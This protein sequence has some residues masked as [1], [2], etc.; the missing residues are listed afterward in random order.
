MDANRW[1]KIKEVYDRALDLRDEERAG[2]LAEACGDDDD[3]RRE[4]QSLLAAHADAGT[5]LESPAVEAAAREIVADEL[6]SPAPQLIGREL[7]NYRIVSLLGRG[8]MGEV[9]L[10]EDK[11]LHRKV[12]LKLLPAQ[13]T[14]AAERVRRFE[15]EAR[16]A[17]ATNHPNIL[18]IYEIGHA[19]G[20]Q[21]IATEFVDGVTLRQSMQNDG[22]S[23][24]ESISVAVQSSSALSAAHE[25]GIIHRDI[26]PENIMV[27]PDGLVKVLDFGLAKLAER[28]AATPEV[29]SRT[30]TSARLSTEPG[31]VMGT[32]SYMSPEQARGQEVDHRTDIFSLGVILFEMIARRRPFEGETPS[33]VSAALLTASPPKLRSLASKAPEELERITKKCLAKG[34]NERYQTA[35]ELLI[36]LSRL[37]EEVK[38]GASG[39]TWGRV[40]FDSHT[41]LAVAALVILMIVALVYA[42]RYRG[43]SATSS[44]LGIKSLAVL[45]LKSLDLKEEDETL[46]LKLADALILRL[47]RLR[48]IVVR[49]VRAMQKYLDKNLDP[50]AAGREQQ[51]DAVLDGSFQS[52]G[53]RIRVRIRLLRVSD[54]Q[55]LWAEII[56]EPGN[57]PFGLQDAL[58][59]KTAQAL[60]PQL[61]GAE[62]KLLARHDTGNVEA[63]RLYTDGRF[64]WNKR[65][66]EGLQKSFQLFQKAVNL[67]PQY[68]RAYAALADSYI[69]LSDYS[70]LPANDAFPKA[71]DAAQRAVDIDDSLA[72]AHTAIAMIKASYNFDWLGAER[73]FEQAIAKNPYYPTA[74]QW[75]AEFLC[76]MGKHE[77]ALEQIHQ[78]QQLDPASLIIQAIE[79]LILNYGRNYE[80][81]I[82]QCL[83]VIDRD[84]NFGEAYAF[85]GFAYEQQGEFRKAMAAYQ[86]YSTL[87]GT[88]TLEAA[89]IRASQILNAR[90]YWQK[91][92]KLSKPPLG[93]EFETACALARL[94][95]TDKALDMLEQAIDKHTYGI[96]YLKVHPNL[97]P[98]RTDPRFQ[99]MLRRMNLKP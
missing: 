91:M 7:A 52:D 30:Q 97:D 21:F 6:T 1:K 9:Y 69:T 81:A 93:T 67:D 33:D 71:R 15:R 18:T 66:V 2:F 40:P 88:N 82:T 98:L 34:C 74:H 19:E 65:N 70:L 8:G 50:L 95:E 27:R 3:L 16:A 57:D 63:H 72:E 73:S 61:T 90:D 22:M 79:A 47:G 10:A 59:E 60:I 17:S 31:V 48:Q 80:Q 4:V 64:Y 38:S 37:G 23:I 77:K 56:D 58:A 94:G 68:A 36:E 25:A 43:E 12:A 54:G 29:D 32:V 76:G 86:K 55:Q 62:R 46:G 41:V 85:L 78:A 96:V 89:A 51:V 53:A 24:A 14:N 35:R 42:M 45:P 28:P 99:D 84:L 75:Y 44:P 20:L 49:P 92:I 83:R 13:F 26:K 11:R 5:F 87:M 39:R